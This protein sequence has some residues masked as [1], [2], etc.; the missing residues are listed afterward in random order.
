MPIKV[1]GLLGSPRRKGNNE[2]LLDQALSGAQS[3]GAE[4]EKIILNELDITPC[5]ACGGCLPAGE[6][7]IQDDMEQIYPELKL[8]QHLILASPVFFLDLPAQ[9]KLLIDRCQCLWV[10]RSVLTHSIGSGQR[11]GLLILT[12]SCSDPRQFQPL[13]PPVRAFFN[14]LG[15]TYWGELLFSG[16]E[17]RGEVL[18][19]SETLEQAFRAGAKLVKGEEI[20]PLLPE[21]FLY[22]IGWVRNSYRETLPGGWETTESELIIEPEL[23][24][25]LD[26]LEDF[27]HLI[28]LF[29]MHSAKYEGQV[30]IHPQGRK[31]MP[32]VGL[33][34]SRSPHR[35]N[36][37]GM[38]VVRL[39]EHR[40]RLLRVQGLDAID[41]T[42]I[43]DLKPY[44]PSDEVPG[45]QRPKW[46]ASISKGYHAGI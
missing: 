11:R 41:G 31:E 38:T 42:P 4:V 7:I 15:I 23:E 39:L 43:I 25:A 29:W 28:V 14:T 30:K 19:R 18:Y 27:S 44:L 2:L 40:G 3:E 17:E 12:A 22:P 36:P 20:G 33:L 46:V 1:L 26:G 8:A 24:P 5:Q 9:V 45:A 21:A 10:W 37:I 35:P 16:L 13:L 6:C 34:A 32:L